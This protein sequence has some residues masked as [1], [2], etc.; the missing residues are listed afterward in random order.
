[1]TFVNKGRYPF[2][3][4]SVARSDHH[5]QGNSISPDLALFAFNQT[6]EWALQNNVDKEKIK[7]LQSLHDL[8]LLKNI[9][10]KNRQTKLT[11]YLPIELE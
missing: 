6:L 5:H 1:M 11:Q 4:R 10:R 3:G 9:E 2:Q 7:V 8:A